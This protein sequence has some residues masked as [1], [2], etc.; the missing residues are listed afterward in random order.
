MLTDKEQARLREKNLVPMVLWAAMLM[1]VFIY[2]G[3]SYLTK[4][5]EIQVIEPMVRWVF[6]FVALTSA[7]GSLAVSQILMSPS[8]LRETLKQ[9]ARIDSLMAKYLTTFIL[10]LALSESVAIFGLVLAMMTGDF[11]EILPFAGASIVLIGLSYPSP[12]AL[13]N[14][15]IGL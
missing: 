15:L 8:K 10:R 12:N 7:I 6:A 11:G 2:V 5:Q 9:E 4:Q 14:R 1:S 13:K 3:V